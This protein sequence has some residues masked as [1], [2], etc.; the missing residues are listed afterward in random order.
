MRVE[1]L[2]SHLKIDGISE[3][4]RTLA[5]AL[6]REE[7]AVR[8]ARR[9]GQ[10][11]GSRRPRRAGRRR[12]PRRPRDPDRGDPRR[13]LGRTGRGP[14]STRTRRAR[15]SNSTTRDRSA[16]PEA[17]PRRLASFWP[18]SS[19][20]TSASRASAL[21]AR[22]SSGT[23]RRSRSTSIYQHLQYVPTAEEIDLVVPERP[24]CDIGRVDRR[25]RGGERV[26]QPASG[27][28]QRHPRGRLPR[29]RRG[30]VPEG[31]E[32]PQGSSRNSASTAGSSWTSWGTPTRRTRTTPRAQVPPG[33]RRGP[34]GAGPSEP[35]GGIPTGLRAGPDH[36]LAACAINPATMVILQHFVAIGTQ[37]KLEYPGKATAMG[38]CDTIEG[39]I[40]EL[41]DGTLTAVHE[42][43]TAL[44]A[45]A[46]RPRIIDLGEILVSYGEFLENN[47]PLVTRG[48]HARLARGGAQPR[49]VPTPTRSPP[50]TTRTP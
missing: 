37:V 41:E 44:D 17:P 31:G 1:K 12:P 18:T 30:A 9:L 28:D 10:R 13:P 47:R 14:R 15:T 40:V 4:I 50:S 21:T 29:H 48:L 35:S 33:C 7:V 6:P 46:Q 36:G 23:R 3:E 24:R 38:V 42:P 25:R 39:P 19:G 45:P 32:A 34:T 20:A 27:P 5:A 26:P 43:R 22:R 8:I 2:L 11:Y 16:P 49:A